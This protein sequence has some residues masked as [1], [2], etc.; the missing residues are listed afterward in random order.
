MYKIQFFTSFKVNEYEAKITLSRKYI[1]VLVDKIPKGTDRIAIVETN[2][3][4]SLG[5]LQSKK[6]I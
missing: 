5:L 4:K 3:S 2:F 6:K 1:A